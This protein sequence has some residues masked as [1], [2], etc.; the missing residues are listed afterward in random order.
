[1]A[2][3]EKQRDGLVAEKTVEWTRNWAPRFTIKRDVT[4]D[5]MQGHK[6]TAE[7]LA[8][9]ELRSGG[10][11]TVKVT[12]NITDG[13]CSGCTAPDVMYVQEARRGLAP[14]YGP[15]IRAVQTVQELQIVPGAV[16][17]LNNCVPATKDLPSFDWGQS[18]ASK[19]A[20]SRWDDGACLQPH[21]L[22]GWYGFSGR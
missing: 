5:D 11:D 22:A 17:G 15:V 13:K 20:S 16:L 7:S 10:A 9:Q 21:C 19:M 3:D 1:V 14:V 4:Q 12:L 8:L 18:G 2:K 6:E